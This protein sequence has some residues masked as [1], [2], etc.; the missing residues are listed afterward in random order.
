LPSFTEH[1]QYYVP[2]EVGND[3]QILIS[4]G[5]INDP[6]IYSDIKTLDTTATSAQSTSDSEALVGSGKITLHKVSKTGNYND[7]LN[8]PIIP[9]NT[10]QKVKAKNSG[11]DVTFGDNAVVEIKAGTNVQV[12]ANATDNTITISSTDTNT[13]Y[14][15]AS[16]DGNGQ[17]KVTPSSG[18]AYNV[19][20]K[21]LGS[22]AYKSTGT[23]SGNV[24]VLDSNGKLA[25]SVIP[26]VAITDTYEASS[27][28]AMLALTAQKGDICI[29]S[30][31]NKSF[32][33][34]TAPASTLANWKELKTPT[35]AVL[36]VNGQTG[37]V[38]LDAADVGAATSTHKHSYTPAGSVSLGSND[39]ASGGVAYVASVSGTSASG[40]PTTRYLHKAT[41]NVSPNAHTHTVTVSGTTGA[42]GGTKVTAVTGVGANGTAD[43]NYNAIK[44]V[45]LSA[46]TT[47]TDGPVYVSG[48]SG[49]SAVTP[50]TKYMKFNAGT[51]PPSSATFSGTK[52]NSLVTAV[53]VN[54]QGSVTLS[55][56]RSTSGSGTS[57]RRTLTITGSH[58]GTTLTVTKGDYTPTGTVSFTAGTAPSMNFNTGKNTDTPYISAVS[59]GSEVTV[60][61]HYMKIETTNADTKTVLTG[62]KATSTAEVAPNAHTHS[63][64]S[65]T[66]L[67]TS[68]NSGSAVAAVTGLTVNEEQTTGDIKYLENYAVSGGTVSGTTKYFHPS[69]SGTAKDTGEPK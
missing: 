20:V 43:V 16:G 46:S 12:A 57:A 28:S 48:V 37:A 69:F 18:N 38:T 68:A 22:A 52:T 35:D 21:G 34:Q 4:T 31:L 33:L 61:T 19:D 9:T 60:T 55:G 64:G 65:S 44:G 58:S 32:V 29:R 6:F 14:T 36:S 45:S 54:S 42:N 15:V 62:V 53:S 3:G 13:T 41:T 59:G 7:L 47:S 49:G 67:P 11:T 25:E 8:K 51:T 23:S 66:A 27:Q 56:S 2:E 5:D 30:D 63:Y 26:A 1:H 40:T 50:T 17:I 39:T 10:N 24:P